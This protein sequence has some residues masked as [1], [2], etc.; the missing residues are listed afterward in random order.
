MLKLSEDGSKIVEVWSDSSLD[1]RIGN[2]VVL[3]GRIYGAGIRQ[4]NCNV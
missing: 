1:P 2:V 3:N 4:K